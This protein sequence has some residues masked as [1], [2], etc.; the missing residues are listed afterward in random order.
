MRGTCLPIIWDADFLYGPRTAAG[1]DTYVLCEINVSSVMP[2]PDQAPAEIARL[3]RERLA[4]PPNERRPCDGTDSKPT[5]W[6]E[7][8][9]ASIM[10]PSRG[11]SSPR[12]RATC[13]R[14]RG[15]ESLIGLAPLPSSAAETDWSKIAAALG[16][17]GTEMPGG[18]YRV[19]LPRTDLHV[20]LDGVELKPTFAL[21]SW[22]AFRRTA[23]PP[24]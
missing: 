22:L 10:R 24:W 17:S 12:H 23:T 11:R 5:R 16:K 21:G 14:R 20:T 2:I 9:N 15:R 1:D 19:G 18:V 4:H 7:A 3:A 8:M 13:L 6:R